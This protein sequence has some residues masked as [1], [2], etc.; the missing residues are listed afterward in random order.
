M[1]APVIDRPA[2]APDDDVLAT[3]DFAPGCDH[4]SCETEAVWV[5]R[6]QPAPCR[7]ADGS[8]WCTFHK[9]ICTSPTP[10]AYKCHRCEVIFDASLVRWEPLRC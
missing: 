10:E 4:L 7:H 6:V 1:T 2:V 8:L 3:L 5:A 9:L